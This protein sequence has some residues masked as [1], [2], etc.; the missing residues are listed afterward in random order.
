MKRVARFDPFI[1]ELFAR[2]PDTK[3]T[4]VGPERS[5]HLW[6]A[7]LPEDLGPGVHT[8]TARAVDEYGKRH[9]ASLVLE[10]LGR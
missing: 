7:G 1:E 6:A 9:E 5:T 2:H 4:W 8:L 3:K 10:V